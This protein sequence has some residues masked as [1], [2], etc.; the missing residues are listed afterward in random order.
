MREQEGQPVGAEVEHLDLPVG[1]SRLDRGV[2]DAALVEA[3]ER[4]L[5]S[6]VVQA[7]A[8]QPD[9]QPVGHDGLESRVVPLFGQQGEVWHGL[10]HVGRDA[11]I[12]RG[13]ELRQ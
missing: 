13:A 4:R 7:V 2:L 9:E 3:A 10:H 1:E 8:A 11:R 6:H 5:V 12:A